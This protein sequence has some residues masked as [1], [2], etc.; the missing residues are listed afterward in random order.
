MSARAKRPTD[1]VQTE[2]YDSSMGKTT[3][4][5]AP[6]DD[7]ATE[8]TQQPAS[9]GPSHG[10]SPSPT[11]QG[12]ARGGGRTAMDMSAAAAPRSRSAVPPSPDPEPIRVI[13]LKT[14]AELAA[15]KRAEKKSRRL[16]QVQIRS[17]GEIS[18]SHTPPRGVGNLAPPRDAHA[19]RIRHARSNILWA[20][21]A[22][23]VA[24]IVATAVW[25][26]GRR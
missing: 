1:E 19:A 2:I 14:P 15:A 11:A 12:Y 24:L 4:K 9:T 23:A 8:K 6:D 25:L 10:R 21:A 13:S 22:L 17:I 16:P 20:A 5:R 18:G 3:V 26:I 7:E